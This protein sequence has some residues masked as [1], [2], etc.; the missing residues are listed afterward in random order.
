MVGS[1]SIP[2]LPIL[3]PHTKRL[4]NISF[5]VIAAIRYSAMR[6]RPLLNLKF[7]EFHVLRNKLWLL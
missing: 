6:E 5:V 2:L 1:S 3:S 7:V 4:T